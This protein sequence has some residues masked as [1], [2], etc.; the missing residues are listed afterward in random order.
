ML[1]MLS[2]FLSGLLALARI[3]IVNHIF[4][5]GIDQDAYQAAFTLPDLI[6]Y[7]LIG[8]AASISVITILNRYRVTPP[9]PRS[10]P[11]SPVS[12]CPRSSSSSSAAS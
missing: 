12:C 10:Q 5:A 9:A 11:R 7:F 4:G 3:K 2:A 6:N 8:G 1:L